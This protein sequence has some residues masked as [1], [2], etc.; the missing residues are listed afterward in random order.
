MIPKDISSEVKEH[1]A[2]SKV[3]GNKCRRMTEKSLEL[4]SL[5]VRDDIETDWMNYDLR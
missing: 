5:F 1:V 4:F 2:R 3:L